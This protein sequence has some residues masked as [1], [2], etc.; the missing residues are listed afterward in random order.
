MEDSEIVDILKEIN[1]R[2]DLPVDEELLVQIMDREIRYPLDEDRG[3]CQEQILTIITQRIGE[4]TR[5]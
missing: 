5:S 2:T 1:K 3:K 4:A